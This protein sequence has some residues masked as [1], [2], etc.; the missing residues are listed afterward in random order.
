MFELA[1]PYFFRDWCVLLRLVYY[2]PVNWLELTVYETC[3][4]LLTAYHPAPESEV[5]TEL[6]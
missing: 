1:L 5:E 2:L 3:D 6:E 4:A